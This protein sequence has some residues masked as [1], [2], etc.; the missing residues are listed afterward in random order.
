MIKPL[1]DLRSIFPTKTI[2]M[3]PA[4]PPRPAGKYVFQ[5]VAPGLGNVVGTPGRVLQL[6]SHVI[7]FDPKTLPQI[8][9]RM[10]FVNAVAAWHAATQEEKAVAIPTAE[11]KN[12]TLFNAYISDWMRANHAPTSTSWDGGATTWDNGATTWDA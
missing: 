11:Q 2:S 4:N 10:H 9:H 3:A 8:F 5:R 7:P 1:N 6:R 12:I